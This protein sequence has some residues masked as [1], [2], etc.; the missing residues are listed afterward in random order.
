MTATRI[1]FEESVPSYCFKSSVV[2]GSSLGGARSVRSGC[3]L[4]VFGKKSEKY[5]KGPLRVLRWTVFDDEREQ[6]RQVDATNQIE[7][8]DGGHCDCANLR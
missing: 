4:V 7:Q 3:I 1:G 2:K 8:P 6:G 5:L